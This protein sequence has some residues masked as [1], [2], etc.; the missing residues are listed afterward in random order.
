MKSS[1]SQFIRATVALGAGSDVSEMGQGVIHGLPTILAECGPNGASAEAAGRQFYVCPVHDRYCQCGL[2]GHSRDGRILR[3]RRRR[4]L[5]L[6]ANAEQALLARMALLWSHRCS[7]YRRSDCCIMR[8]SST[9]SSPPFCF[10]CHA[11][12][13]ESETGTRGVRG[14][15]ARLGAACWTGV[16]R[17]CENGP[18]RL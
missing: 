18:R 12:R 7:G 3:V 11:D 17:A 6:V 9:A 4:C 2:A 1:R 16:S 13:R 10:S 14:V 15:V 5:Q 8:R